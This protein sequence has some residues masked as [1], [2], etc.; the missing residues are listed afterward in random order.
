[1]RDLSCSEND[2]YDTVESTAKGSTQANVPCSE[3]IAYATVNK[4]DDNI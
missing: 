4:A 3:N 1:M 2:A